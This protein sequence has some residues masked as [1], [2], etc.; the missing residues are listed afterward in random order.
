MFLLAVDP[1]DPAL[2]IALDRPAAEQI[3]DLQ[4]WAIIGLSLLG[5]Y[6]LTS[7]GLRYTPW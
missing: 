4:L 5:A 3:D 6:L 7:F 1:R 2:A